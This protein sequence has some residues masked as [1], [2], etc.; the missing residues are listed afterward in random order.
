MSTVTVAGKDHCTESVSG[1]EGVKLAG[2]SSE[3][4]TLNVTEII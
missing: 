3:T 1:K 4:C 2:L